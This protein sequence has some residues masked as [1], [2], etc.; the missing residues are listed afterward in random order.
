M[1]FANLLVELQTHTCSLLLSLSPVTRR[2]Y[3]TFNHRTTHS[4]SYLCHEAIDMSNVCSKSHGYFVCKMAFLSV[5]SFVMY[6]ASGWSLKAAS[7]LLW[8]IIHQSFWTTVP[9]TPGNAFCRKQKRNLLSWSFVMMADKLAEVQCQF[10]LDG[11]S[12][13]A[14]WKTRNLLKKH[15]KIF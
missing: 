9:L 10:I 13:N 15:V 7:K 6:I 12:E 14:R 1:T 8:L 5:M 2:H 4:C 11:E 3:A